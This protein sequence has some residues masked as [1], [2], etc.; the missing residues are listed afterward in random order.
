MS[1]ATRAGDLYYTFR[2]VKLLT[3]PWVEMDAYKLGI[4]DENGKRIKSKSVSTGEEKSAFT[5]FHKLVFNL[6]RLIERLP[7]GSSK[8]ASYASAL[9]LLKE[10]YGLSAAAVEKIIAR[11]DV[12]VNDFIAEN[13]EW[14]VLENKQL[15]KGMYRVREEKLLSSTCDPVVNPNDRI[16]VF[17][18]AYPVGDIMGIDVY[19]AMHVNTNQKIYVTLGEIYK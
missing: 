3:T 7:G 15:A 10:Q 12:S 16:K 2:F 11:M 1:L 5:T 4:I 6:K 14:Y 9:F 13:Y 17:D 18:D 19:E 8:I